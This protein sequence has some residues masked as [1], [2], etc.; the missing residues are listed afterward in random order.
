MK[1]PTARDRDTIIT[2]LQQ[3]RSAQE[4][5]LC[6]EAGSGGNPHLMPKT[7]TMEMRELE[8][9]LSLLAH[10]KPVHHRHTMARYVDPT[11]ARR[12][13]AGRVTRRGAVETMVWP[14]LGAN[15]AVITSAKLPEHKGSSTYTCLVATW[16]S[17]VNKPTVEQAVS[18]L[19][20]WYTPPTE[21]VGPALPLEMVPVAA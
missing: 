19:M 20:D 3:F 9:C 7:W 11:V 6:S 2:M 12:T 1:N 4:T 15:A 14:Q 13:M 8:R 10:R 21:S 16:P 18:W 5:L 17:W